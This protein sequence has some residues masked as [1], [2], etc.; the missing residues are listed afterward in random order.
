MHHYSDKLTLINW[1]AITDDVPL[2]PYLLA[3][4]AQY[5]CYSRIELFS[6]GI[7]FN[8]IHVIE[9]CDGQLLF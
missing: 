4:Y 6:Q 8:V 2:L 5:Y 3:T 9:S 1:A 7:I